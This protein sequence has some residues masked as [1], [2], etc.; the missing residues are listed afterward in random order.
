MFEELASH[1]AEQLQENFGNN[2][3]SCYLVG[4]YAQGNVSK[5]RPDIN[6]L[7]IWKDPPTGKEIWTLGE[8]LTNTVNKFEDKYTVRPEFRPFKFSYPVK[9]GEKE[10]FINI[11]NVVSAENQEAFKKKNSYI[12]EYVFLGF[13]ESRKL[14]FGDD[15]L[16]K[17]DFEISKESVRKSAMKKII[18]HKIQLDRIPLVYN[19]E[20]DIDLLFNESLSHA[21]N[22]MYFLVELLMTDEELKDRKFLEL[23]RDKKRLLDFFSSRKPELK[24]T[25]ITILG[26]KKNYEEWKNDR[27]RAKEIY[28]ASYKLIRHGLKEIN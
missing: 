4:S 1:I 8:I 19:L 18:S 13:K 9:R 17:F 5:S 23:Y 10:V 21:K 11:T 26:A 28:Q 12:P 16:E 15:L 14:V 22:L 27:R 24:E 3:K 6:W 25:V 7:L 20:E 2:I